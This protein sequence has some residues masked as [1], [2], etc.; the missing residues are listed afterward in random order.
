MSVPS[1]SVVSLNQSNAFNI[2]SDCFWAT[3]AL[4]STCRPVAYKPV[5][6]SVFL[7]I[8]EMRNPYVN[9]YLFKL[10]HGWIELIQFL[11]V[12]HTHTKKKKLK[13]FHT[14]GEFMEDL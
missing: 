2:G 13:I 1:V 9:C 7:F 14:P 6:V 4:L 8:K 12:P 5:I 11:Y 10:S 3:P